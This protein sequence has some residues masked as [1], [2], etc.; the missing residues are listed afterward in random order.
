VADLVE[1]LAELAE[2][3]RR[4]CDGAAW[5]SDAAELERGLTA[6]VRDIGRLTVPG[7]HQ[8]RNVEG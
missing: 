8:A 2:L 1:R 7:W 6:L 4:V 5:D 3:A